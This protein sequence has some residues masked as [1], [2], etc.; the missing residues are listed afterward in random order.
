VELPEGD[1]RRG[2][3]LFQE[4]VRPHVYAG[5]EQFKALAQEARRTL[6]HLAIRWGL[7]QPGITSVLVGARNAAQMEE[8]AAALAG[9]PISDDIFARFT[10]ISDSIMNH[11]PDKGNVYNYYP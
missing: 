7:N 4:A 8:N 9:E 11:I 1:Q 6:P 3:L 5:V 10:E 2:I